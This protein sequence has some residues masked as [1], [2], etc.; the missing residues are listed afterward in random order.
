[1]MLK[2]IKR[3]GDTLILV[4]AILTVAS[5]LAIGLDKFV[6]VD[7]PAWLVYS[8]NFYY[9]LGQKEFEKTVY[10][11]QP[12]VTSMWITTAALVSYFP[13][14]RGQGQGYFTKHWQFNQF[15]DSFDKH[16]LEL[17]RRSRLI[18]LGL[19]TILL[20]FV[21]LMLRLLL[22]RELAFTAALL[23]SLDPYFTGHSRLL[24]HEA[25]MGLFLLISLLSILIYTEVRRRKLLLAISG[26][27]AGLALLTK[28]SAT[29][30]IPLVSLMVLIEFTRRWRHEYHFLK[31]LRV[32]LV[33]FLLWLAFL[34]L[35]YTL[36]WPG[37]WVNPV[38][39]L[40][41]VYGNAFSYAFQ[42]A[43]LSLS[44]ELTPQDFSLETGGIIPY[45]RLLLWGTTPIQWVAVLL[46]VMSVLKKDS[47]F[48]NSKTKVVFVYLG[49]LAVLF[50]LLFGIARG[51]NSP[52]YILT[53][54]MSLDVLAG[55]GIIA[56]LRV[57]G[58]SFPILNR[59]L[60]RRGIL[61]GVLLVQG[62]LAYSQYPY[63]YT[64]TNPVMAWLERGTT[65]PNTGYGEGLD[66]AG[67]YL[68]RKPGAEGLTAMSW[69]GIGPF[70]YF[71]KG[72]TYPLLP[73]N[74]MSGQT[75]DELKDSDYLVIYVVQQRR[76][77]YYQDLMQ[78]LEAVPA[79]HVIWMD[80][81]EY[82]RIYKV[83]LLPEHV[84][85]MLN[86]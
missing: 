6:T 64:Y 51:R 2:T 52:H 49:F 44:Q 63:F 85:T 78:A 53:S 15:L 36:A 86:D 30:I 83:D 57:L 47:I 7:E 18:A 45:I 54:Y 13:Q 16:P 71:F 40:T 73:G 24:N 21:F 20:L 4:A 5:L 80:G 50:I 35:A 17:L 81:I 59:R 19:N 69:Y 76:R 22:D 56:G 62:L 10:E 77:N 8:A 55:I 26:I 72:Q 3:H 74:R 66:L 29:V 42:G 46:A 67:E 32:S 61:L 82:I 75:V 28:S 34:I 1:M 14:Y 41:E 68:S 9:A 79:E 43:R 48:V 84:F 33:V 31:A 27:S 25:L 70:S 38:K 12:A 37:M 39:M 58:A 65:N 60:V 11:Y 23:I